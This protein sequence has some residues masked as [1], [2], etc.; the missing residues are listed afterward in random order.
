M[1]PL[2]AAAQS[3]NPSLQNAS[4]TVPQLQEILAV[5]INA[6]SDAGPDAWLQVTDWNPRRPAAC[7]YGREQGAARRHRHHPAD[8][9]AGV[10][11]PQQLRQ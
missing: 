8:L 10:R 9:P 7:R 4:V 5:F 6:T 3:L 11:L 2:G 1:H